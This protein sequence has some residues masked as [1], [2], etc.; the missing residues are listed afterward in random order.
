MGVIRTTGFSGRASYVGSSAAQAQAHSKQEATAW[1]S[2][3]RSS[4]QPADS[5]TGVSQWRQAPTVQP[6]PGPG[7]VVARS[8]MR[9]FSSRAF[10]FP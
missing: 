2:P 5:H 9:L 3:A 10:T 7:S 8:A 4:T 1:G 6:S